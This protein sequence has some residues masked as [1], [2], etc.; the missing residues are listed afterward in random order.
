MGVPHRVVEGG[1]PKGAPVWS[2]MYYWG[3]PFGRG[4][5]PVLFWSGRTKDVTIKNK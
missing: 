2:K 3:G 4:Y 1:L 5:A